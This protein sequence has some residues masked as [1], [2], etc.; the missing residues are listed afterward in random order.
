MELLVEVWRST[1]EDESQRR[2][3]LETRATTITT[4]AA[5]SATLVATQITDLAHTGEKVLAAL[6]L[7]LLAAAV[8]LSMFGLVAPREFDAARKLREGPLRR[9]KEGAETTEHAE[10]QA[11]RA[12]LEQQLQKCLAMSEAT[13]EDFPV[14]TRVTI[15]SYWKEY[16]D[17]SHESYDIKSAWTVYATIVLGAALILFVALAVVATY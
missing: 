11:A 4:A 8:A 7:L 14:E 16:A 17:S 3:K 10:K 9:W 13:P 5:V 1:Y 6:A 15:A 2:Q 12:S